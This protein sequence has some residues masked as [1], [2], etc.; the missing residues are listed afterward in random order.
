[1]HSLRK[2]E[3]APVKDDVGL[4]ICCRDFAPV[5]N[6]DMP[7][8]A[9]PSA[10]SVRA[11]KMRDFLYY[12]C[13]GSDG[14][15]FGGEPICS[16]AQIQ[17]NILETTVWSEVSN[18]LMNPQRVELEHQDRTANSMLLENLEHL[19][20]QKTKLEHAVER[21]IDSFAE[22]L[23]EKDQFT[24]RM[25]RT[26]NR[27]ADL[28]TRIRAY[29]GNLDQREHLRLT[30]NRLRE[31]VAT[32]GPE[33]ESA[34][35]QRKREIIQTVVQRIDIDTDVMKIIFCVNPNTRTSDSD[36]IAISVPRPSKRFR[37]SG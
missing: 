35:W 16:N 5:R 18:L 27:I 36:G 2:I 8:T 28:D 10:N 37:Y 21:L 4:G 19:E 30:A 34:D 17:G 14:Y 24:S 15:R 3:V 25:A 1:M 31:L 20:A 22:G 11:V 33:L 7:I 9:R 23:I 12:R 32:V 6:A 29:A 26:K 13:S